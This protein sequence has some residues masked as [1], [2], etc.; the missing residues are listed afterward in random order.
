MKSNQAKHEN[1]LTE[2]Q[3]KLDVL[4]TRIN[5]VYERVSHLEDKMMEKKEAEEKRK[6]TNEPWGE[7]SRNH[8]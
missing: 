6:T 8:Q 5:E 2:M 1:A 3:A 7:A 4:T